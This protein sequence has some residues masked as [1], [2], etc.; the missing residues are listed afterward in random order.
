M[1][2]RAPTNAT[3]PS[4]ELFFSWASCFGR[5]RLLRLGVGPR[6]GSSALSRL[7]PHRGHR[8][9][10]TA[11]AAESN[12]V[13][14]WSPEVTNAT[15]PWEVQYYMRVDMLLNEVYACARAQVRDLAG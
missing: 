9:L 2:S 15:D 8:S 1:A 11:A 10:A 12:E 6:F 5:R 7:W 4:V 13:D 14:D 3:G